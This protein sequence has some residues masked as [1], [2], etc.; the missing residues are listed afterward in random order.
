ME[1][2]HR[3]FDRIPLGRTL[4]SMYDEP[5]VQVAPGS[6]AARNPFYER[7]D[8]AHKAIRYCEDLLRGHRKALGTD[9]FP[10]KEWQHPV[11]LKALADLDGLEAQIA[12]WTQERDGVQ[13][14]GE[15]FMP[16]IAEWKALEAMCRRD[17]Q[18]LQ[19]AVTEDRSQT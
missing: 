3:D 17:F 2:I 9:R 8:K 15:A 6:Q 5:E 4:L 13:A 1:F 7:L 14:R 19:V 12:T 10:K 18:L 16:T 11:R